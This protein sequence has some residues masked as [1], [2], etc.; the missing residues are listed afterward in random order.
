MAGPSNKQL[1][2]EVNAAALW[3][4][5]RKTRAI[6]VCEILQDQVIETL[7]GTEHVPAGNVLCRGEAGDLWP[8][9][10]ERLYEKYR[11]TTEHQDNWQKFV[12]HPD[13]QGVL[14]AQIDHPFS[15]TAAW[16]ILQGKAGDFLLKN[17]AD[18]DSSYPDDIWIVDQLLF[19]S[20]YQDVS[21]P[22]NLNV[23]GLSQHL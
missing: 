7:E 1:L 15:V 9:T 6:W 8:Q 2:D 11:P 19:R 20:T 18:R 21:N 10:R 16:G 22:G 17:F 14:A 5:A 13:D 4:H 3:F 12:P 23:S